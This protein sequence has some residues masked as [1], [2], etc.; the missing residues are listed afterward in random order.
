MGNRHGRY[1]ATGHGKHHPH[2][3]YKYDESVPKIPTQTSTSA[4]VNMGLCLPYAHVDSTLRAL[5]G[6]AEG[7]GRH[8]IG[9]LHGP[10]YHVKTLAGN[11]LKITGSVFKFFF[12][13]F[14]YSICWIA[15]VNCGFT[16]YGQGRVVFVFSRW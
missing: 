1:S 10:L 3:P 4:N 16:V 9:G 7:F 11:L 6:Q 5:A 2:P 12:S 14:D 13:L 15:L 8:A